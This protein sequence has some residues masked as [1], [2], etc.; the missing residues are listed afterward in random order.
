MKEQTRSGV[1]N[2]VQRFHRHSNRFAQAPARI[3][4]GNMDCKSG[5]DSKRNV[6]PE[7]ARRLLLELE[8]R[9][10]QFEKDRAWFARQILTVYEDKLW[11]EVTG[12][13]REYV[14]V[15]LKLPLRTA[16]EMIRVSKAAQRFGISHDRIADIGWSKLAL[17]VNDLTDETVD[18]VLANAKS[19]SYKALRASRRASKAS[20]VAQEEYRSQTLVVSAALRKAIIRASLFT[21]M[22]DEQANLDYIAKTFLTTHSPPDPQAHLRPSRN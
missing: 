15:R 6:D 17:V 5:S 9:A 19:E 8:T 3:G 12:S 14:E 16:Q 13:F 20:R 21:R 10:S 22:E 11:K 2:E 4:R 1:M 7:S 18:D